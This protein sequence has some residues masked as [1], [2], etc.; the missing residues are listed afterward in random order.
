MLIE[1]SPTEE[2]ACTFGDQCTFGDIS[3]AARG[4]ARMTPCLSGACVERKLDLYCGRARRCMS[5]SGPSC[6]MDSPLSVMDSC[7]VDFRVTDSPLVL[8][9]PAADMITLCW[10]RALA[11]KKSISPHN[12]GPPALAHPT[13]GWALISFHLRPY[14]Y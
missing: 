5:C 9:L 14:M 7:V 3:A 8:W 1:T 12:N 10:T 13:P 11:I 6:V 2:V 4:A